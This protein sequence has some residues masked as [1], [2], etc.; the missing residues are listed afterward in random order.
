MLVV[1]VSMCL[2]VSVFDCLRALLDNLRVCAFACPCV[3]V[4]VCADLVVCL[5]L[6]FD[7]FVC[8]F[9][10]CMCSGCLSICYMESV[11][12]PYGIPTEFPCNA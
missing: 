12:T 3:F 9:C 7:V 10:R 4:C 11:Q 8:V 5:P 6:C 1:Y 2:G